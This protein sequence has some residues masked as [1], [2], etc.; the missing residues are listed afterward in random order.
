M[1]I[2]MVIGQFY[3]IVGGAE[4]QA[5]KLALTLIS[6]GIDVD[7]LTIHRRGLSRYEVVNGIRIFR[8]SGLGYKKIKRYSVLWSIYSFILQNRNNY[9]IIHIHQGLL[10]AYA[11]SLA[12]KK[13]KIPSLVKIGSSGYNFDLKKVREKSWMGNHIYNSIKNNVDYFISITPQIK[14]ELIT[15][16]IENER[17]VSIPNGVE[18]KRKSKSHDCSDTNVDI[19]TGVAVGRLCHHKNYDFLFKVISKIKNRENYRLYILGNGPD[20]HKLKCLAKSLCIE[21][22]LVFCGLVNNV[23]EYLATADFF[24]LPS[25]TEGLSNALLEAMAF[26]VV[27]VVSDIPGNRFVVANENSAGVI[28]KV[29]S[30]DEWIKVFE[31]I[32]P[33]KKIMT[34]LRDNVTETITNRFSIDTI[35]DSYISLYLKLI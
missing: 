16:G 13:S 27:P 8:L 34:S 20:E 1:K 17:I 31:N 26:G 12:A 15:S 22:T 9:D 19:I 33:N 10:P 35:A 3:P 32:I 5:N 14:E 2:L 18:I 21:E 29:N 11:A 30:T 25:K 28:A 24:V 6:K 7:I 4:V 23:D